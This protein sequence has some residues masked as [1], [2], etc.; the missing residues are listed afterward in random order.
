MVP[1]AA[2]RYKGANK[3]QILFYYIANIEKFK[4][5]EKFVYFLIG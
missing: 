2:L 5:K 1:L 4:M 3:D